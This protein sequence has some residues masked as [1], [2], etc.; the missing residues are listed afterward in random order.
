MPTCQHCHKPT[1]NPR[2]CNR[3]CAASYNNRVSP[4]R[5][6][7]G[8]CADCPTP[9]AP[10][11]IRC[12]T[13]KAAYRVQQDAAEARERARRHA[14]YE[15]AR[16]AAVRHPAPFRVRPD[17]PLHPVLE[18][19]ELH[20]PILSARLSPAQALRDRVMLE[21]LRHYALSVRIEGHLPI[22]RSFP[23]LL[24]NWVRAA[25]HRNWR[26]PRTRH[27]LLSAYRYAAH[28]DFLRMAFGYYLEDSYDEQ[29]GFI[30]TTHHARDLGSSD[31]R[32]LTQDIKGYLAMIALPEHGYL[33][34]GDQVLAEP[35]ATVRGQLERFYA[36]QTLTQ[37]LPV[38]DPGRRWTD[39]LPI[40]VTLHAS[41]EGEPDRYRILPR[42][43]AIPDTWIV[44]WYE[45]TKK[46]TVW[47]AVDWTDPDGALET[48][49]R[50][51]EIRKNAR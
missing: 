26:H 6:K 1:D 48:L 27:P 33:H 49:L 36:S 17:A 43:F 16:A 44:E 5:K 18:L 42:A 29:R 13:C 15:A 38:A 32:E 9:I 3:S 30:R 25:A 47:D 14:E 39:A 31:L 11:Q 28:E 2:F 20:W 40:P 8:V 7:E 34:W 24:A 12:P 4:K 37:D 10:S 46:S 19:M 41:V 51:S 35:G 50:P 45:N 23:L 22:E 21:D